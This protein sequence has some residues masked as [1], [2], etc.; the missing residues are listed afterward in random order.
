MAILPEERFWRTGTSIGDRHIY[1]CLTNDPSKPH[2]DD[3]LVAV[4]ESP[5]V[6]E[7]IVDTHNGA[8]QQYGKRYRKALTSP[9]TAS[10]P[11][12]DEIYIRLSDNE[13]KA[14]RRL[15]GWLRTGMED[16]GNSTVR[17]GVDKLY[18]GLGGTV[19]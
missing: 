5:D 16:L 1:A 12:P 19:G 14:M 2:A 10:E 18:K 13:R 11:D 9:S 8:L 6:A 4:V 17:R 7:D 3:L 15:I